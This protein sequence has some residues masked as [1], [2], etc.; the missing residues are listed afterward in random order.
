MQNR[1]A[2]ISILVSA[3]LLAGVGIAIPMFSPLKIVIPPASYTLA[4]HV[5]IFMAMFISPAA[6]VAVSLVT[7]VGFLLG[8][9]AP[10]IVMRALTHVVFA[11]L[12]SLYLQKNPLALTRF[13]T[14]ITFSAL[15]GLLHGLLEV[16]A[17]TPFFYGGAL[18]SQTYTSGFFVAIIL[19][20]GVGT[21][22]HS[23]V[24]FAISHWIWRV[25][26][27]GLPIKTTV[28]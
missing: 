12:G 19:L 28:R 23:M 8:G 9:F 22:V 6:A 14:R 27:P 10:V 11:A 25:I 13:K 26:A 20:V 7:T 24:D 4:S 18:S 3:S 5:P 1:S 17:V 16:L 21:L 2:G 15:V